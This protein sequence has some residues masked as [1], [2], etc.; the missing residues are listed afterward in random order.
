MQKFVSNVKK[1]PLVAETKSSWMQNIGRHLQDKSL[2]A[3]NLCSELLLTFDDTVLLSIEKSGDE[4]TT[5]KKAVLHHKFPNHNLTVAAASPE[6]YVDT[7]G[8]YWDVPLSLAVDLAS[9]PS[10][11]GLSYHLCAQHNSGTAKQFESDQ[12]NDEIPATL[13]PGI[14]VKSAFSYKKNIDIWRSEGSK[15]KMVQPYDM[16]TSTPHIS[17]SGIIGAVMNASFG[18]N[19][20]RAKAGDES[21]GLRGFSFHNSR[22]KA[23]LSADAF[24]STTFTAQYGNFQK[25]FFDLT[26]FHARLDFPSGSELIF[27]A[28]S[29]AHKFFSS[30][31]PS[32][33]AVQALCPT[34]ATLSLQQQ[35]VG[36]FSFRVETEVA[37]DFKNGSWNL[38]VDQPV[39]AIEHALQVL[40]SAKAIAWYSPKHKE[41]MMELRFFEM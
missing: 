34:A 24:V 31:N 40:G 36:P 16:F 15:I 10:D 18:D 20:L 1:G 11:S 33:E 3:V 38:H 2:Y 6:L 35:L 12:N 14:S 9:V 37:C 8:T 22:M 26:R 21:H 4:K 28:A 5:K 7:S 23:A 17:A 27:G 25:I 19:Y 13:L 30:Q 41:F 39:F 32:V 29:L